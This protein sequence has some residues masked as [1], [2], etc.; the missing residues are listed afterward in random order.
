MWSSIYSS[1]ASIRA[2]PFNAV[3]GPLA[4]NNPTH[5]QTA[6]DAAATKALGF[7]SNW[8]YRKFMTDNAAAIRDHNR[9]EAVRASLGADPEPET[10]YT[11]PVDE[12]KMRATLAAKN[13]QLEKR[14]D[15]LHHG[16]VY[17]PAQVE[18]YFERKN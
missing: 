12:N 14:W 3:P 2:S 8:Q 16:T 5:V 15:D 11:L 9:S 17:T 4:T 7:T 1:T 13:A 18:R 10:E 6:A